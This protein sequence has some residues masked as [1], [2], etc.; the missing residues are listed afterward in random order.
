GLQ[1]QDGRGK[2]E[3]RPVR[4]RAAPTHARTHPSKA[5]K[6]GAPKV[7]KHV[8][9]AVLGCAPAARSSRIRNLSQYRWPLS[10]GRGRDIRRPTIP[11]FV[12]QQSEGSGFFCFG[13]QSEFVG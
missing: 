11:S 3:K 2:R 5:A 6:G 4:S 1:P 10:A 13:R 12:R 7:P 9:I 8:G